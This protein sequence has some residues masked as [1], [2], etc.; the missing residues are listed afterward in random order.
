MAFRD[1]RQY[2]AGDNIR[3]IDWNV[4][5]RMSETFV[6][7]FVEERKLTVMLVVESV[8][9]RAVWNAARNQKP[10]WPERSRLSQLAIRANDQ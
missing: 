2:Q 9:E 5:A 7:V 3:R 10:R 4:T 8:F 1:V 6:K